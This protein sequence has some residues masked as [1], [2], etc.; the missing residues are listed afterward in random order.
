MPALRSLS[1]PPAGVLDQVTS[2]LRR[3]A[4]I[5]PMKGSITGLRAGVALAL[6]QAALLK[7]SLQPWLACLRITALAGGAARM[8]DGVSV[9]LSAPA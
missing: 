8:P 9:Q 1:S 4:N 2:A 5:R 7:R 3:L 6:R